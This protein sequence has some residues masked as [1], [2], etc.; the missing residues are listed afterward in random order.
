MCTCNLSL[1]DDRAA[2]AVEVITKDWSVYFGYGFK[3]P[4]HINILEM[5][6]LMSLVRQLGRL[7][8]RFYPYV[9]TLLF[10][11]RVTKSKI[12]VRNG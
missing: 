3:S 4:R 10:T 9:A 6:A 7:L 12:R 1:K 2:A 5:R 8:L 11:H